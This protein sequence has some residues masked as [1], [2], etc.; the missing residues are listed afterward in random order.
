LG[1]K[2]SRPLRKTPRNAP[3]YVLPQTKKINLQ[4]LQNQRYIGIFM[5]QREIGRESEIERERARVRARSR[6]RAGKGQGN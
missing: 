6:A 1:S 5:S 4:D 2:R 3:F